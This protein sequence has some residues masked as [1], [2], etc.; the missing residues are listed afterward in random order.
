MINLDHN[1]TT[2][3]SPGAP[4]AAPAP[5]AAVATLK[6]RSTQRAVVWVD[7]KVAGY[8]PLDQGVPPGTHKVVAMLPGQPETRQ[9]RAVVA[10]PTQATTVDLV[11]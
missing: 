9:Q 10:D 3:P 1:A 5:P 11:F 2:P 6:I 7:D 8:T 4:V